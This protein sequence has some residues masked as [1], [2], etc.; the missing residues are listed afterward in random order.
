LKNL[1]IRSGIRLRSIT[2]L[3]KKNLVTIVIL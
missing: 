1:S 2:G 3:S